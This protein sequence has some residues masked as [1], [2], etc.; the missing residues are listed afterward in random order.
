[1]HPSSELQVVSVNVGLPRAVVW[2]GR[3]VLT[4][5]FK[6]PVAGRI[7]I[8]RLNLEGDRQADL[9]VHGGA[10]KAVY[11]YP[12]E[13]YTFWREQFPEMELPWGMFGE[14]LT[15]KGL[16]D[17]SVHIGDRFQVGRA[18]L[19]VTQPRLPCYKLG[20]KFGRDDILKRFLQSGLTGFYFAVLR[21]GEVAARDPIRLLHRDEDQVTVADITRLY[22]KDRHNL[23][24]LRRVV[25][26]EALPESWRDY[27]LERLIAADGLATT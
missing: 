2:K 16:L 19:V 9:T 27:F 7:A 4:G 6:E 3:T 23:D 15:I 14:N 18:D 12:A 25:A 20:L 11:A 24:L 17:E 10:E 21:E 13:Y 22:R 8:K 1:M 5:I 26:V